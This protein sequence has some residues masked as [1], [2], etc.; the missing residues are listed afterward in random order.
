MAVELQRLKSVL[1]TS[2][3]QQKDPALF[4]VIVNLLD[5]VQ[6]IQNNVTIIT[7]GGGGG[8]SLADKTYVTVNPEQAT[9]PFS[10]QLVAG[11][12]IN[13]NNNG[14]KLILSVALPLLIDALSESD[15]ILGEMGLPGPQGKQGIPGPPGMPGMDVEEYYESMPFV[16]NSLHNGNTVTGEY[17]QVI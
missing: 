13:I 17:R 11:S 8:G 15:A 4:Q 14:T 6:A 12:G 7:G 1:N 3:L 16:G 9:L 10:R 2:G 5:A